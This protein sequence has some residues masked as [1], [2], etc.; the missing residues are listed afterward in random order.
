MARDAHTLANLRQLVASRFPPKPRATAFTLPTGSPPL[1]ATLG[2]GLACG[3]LTEWVS[4]HPSAGSQS[5]LVTFV[6]TCRAHNRRVAW[7]DASAS[8]CPDVLP[9]AE[10]EHL[11]WVRATGLEPAFTAADLL[12]HDGQWPV[13]ILDLRAC[14]ERALRR[15]PAP[16]WYRLQ[17]AAEGSGVATVIATPVALIPAVPTR[18]LFE[19]P[20][21]GVEQRLEPRASFVATLTPRL[22]RQAASA[23]LRIA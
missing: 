1:D 6:R 16:T 19:S 7:V 5:A 21:A 13:L 18:L 9:E 14:D 10:W 12:L 4:V 22:T 20:H 17:R 15:W 3:Q 11:L 23:G 2:G 8:F